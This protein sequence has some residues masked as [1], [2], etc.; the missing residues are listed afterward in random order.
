MASTE[1]AYIALLVTFKH[2][3]YQALRIL[4]KCLFRRYLP[5]WV[6]LFMA[7]FMGF[8]SHGLQLL[9]IRNTISL[10]SFLR[11]VLSSKIGQGMLNSVQSTNAFFEALEVIYYSSASFMNELINMAVGFALF[12]SMKPPIYRGTFPDCKLLPKVLFIK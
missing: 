4:R 8:F 10:P 3:F 6:V 2:Y 12:I 9:V 7:A 1:T 11:R 5:Q